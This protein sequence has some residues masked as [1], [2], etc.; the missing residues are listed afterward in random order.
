MRGEYLVCGACET[1][2]PKALQIK[3][4]GFPVPICGTCGDEL[5][6]VVFSRAGGVL[7]ITGCV[8]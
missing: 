2:V 7:Y 1:I 5:C 8:T 6:H 3:P 4:K